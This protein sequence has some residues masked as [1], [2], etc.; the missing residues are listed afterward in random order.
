MIADFNEDAGKEAEES[1]PGVTFIQV[2]VSSRESVDRLVESVVEQ[3]G[4][5]DILIN[6]AGITRDS[7]LSKMTTSNFSR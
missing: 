5:I 1:T 3:Y 4:K 6:N 2:D 7:M